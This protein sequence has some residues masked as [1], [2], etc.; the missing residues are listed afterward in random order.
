MSDTVVHYCKTC[1]RETPHTRPSTSHVLHLILTLITFGVWLLV[2][3]LVA[4]NNSTQAVCLV[5]GAERGLFGSGT[6]GT[7][8]GPT[9]ETHVRCPDCR[10]LILKEAR[11]CKHCGCRLIPQ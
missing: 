7:P 4:G 9:P 3:I 11:K 8:T 2:W 5:C 10:E 1:Q 6:R